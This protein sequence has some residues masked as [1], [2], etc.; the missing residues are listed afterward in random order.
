MVEI[1]EDILNAESARCVLSVR[2]VVRDGFHKFGGLWTGLMSK[3]TVTVLSLDDLSR[4][5]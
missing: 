3:V 2:Q 4:R 1:S 5:N